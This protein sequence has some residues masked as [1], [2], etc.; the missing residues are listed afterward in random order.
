[1]GTPDF[2]VPCL[3]A[4]QK[5]HEVV[6]VV[7]QPDK[8]QGRGMNVLALP[9][10]VLAVSL[11]L[12]VLQPNDVM[13]EGFAEKLKALRPELGVVVAYGQFLTQEILGIPV[14]GWINVHASLLPKYRGA[15]PITRAICA[16]EA[17]TGLTIQFLDL[18][19]DSG[20]VIMRQK[21]EITD[22]DT[23]E[24]LKSRLQQSAPGL[25]LKAVGLI[26]QGRETREKQNDQEATFAP[27]LR[28]EDGLINWSRSA[29][30]IYNQVRAMD[31]WPA[32]YS[33]LNGKVIKVWEAMVREAD[34]TGQ[35]GIIGEIVKDTG[36]VVSTGKGT[37]LVKTIQA[38]DGKKMNAF[39][40]GL[41]H[42][43]KE[44]MMFDWVRFG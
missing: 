1:M 5:N 2:A 14:K 25:L 3:E 37:L 24:T 44:K 19:M 23:T 22:Q 32:A 15:A 11:G 6:A 12:P 8:P 36:W 42:Q 16:G 18:K 27:M 35:L 20:D 21:V 26:G 9:V 41:G 40:Y 7:V 13:D 43:I 17:E 28:K 33:T 4:L 39:T 34:S 10:K 29:R 31:P 38:Q 30:E